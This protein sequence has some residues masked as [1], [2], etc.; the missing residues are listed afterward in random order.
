MKIKYL[1]LMTLALGAMLWACVEDGKKSDGKAGSSREDMLVGTWIKS[2]DA[3][4]KMIDIGF[5]LMEDQTVN[6]INQPRTLGQEWNVK[7]EDSLIIFYQNRIYGDSI[8]SSVYYIESISETELR[9][10]P[11]NASKHYLDIYSRK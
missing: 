4:N 9:L 7:G 2:I 8:E 10:R 11:R 3:G 6:Y 1:A 5:E